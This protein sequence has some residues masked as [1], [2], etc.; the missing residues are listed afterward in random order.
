MKGTVVGALVASGAS[1]RVMQHGHFF[2]G[3]HFKAQ[4]MRAADRHAASATGATPRIDHGQLAG[5]TRHRIGPAGIGRLRGAVA[6]HAGSPF[7]SPAP[8]ALNRRA[9]TTPE[10]DLAVLR[11]N[12]AKSIGLLRRSRIKRVEF[13]ISVEHVDGCD[14]RRTGSV[15]GPRN[16]LIQRLSWT[17]DRRFDRTVPSVSH[18]ATH[19]EPAGLLDHRPPIA[20]ALHPPA[21]FQSQYRLTHW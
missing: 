19:A 4:Q 10:C 7:A 21:N 6:G 16:E 20:Y 8:H 12:S 17:A 2:P 15:V 1:L 11:R 5:S 14:G 3:N 13:A 18:P 9:E